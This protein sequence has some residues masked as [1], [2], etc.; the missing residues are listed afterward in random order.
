VPS[1][2]SSRIDVQ[3]AYA[4]VVEHLRRAIHLGEYGPGDKFPP[5][6][7]HAGELGVSRVTLRGAIRVLEGEGL[8]ETRRGSA[9]GVTVRAPA[10]TREQIIRRLRE[11]MDELIAIQQFRLVNERLAAER[12]ATRVSEQDIAALELSTEQLA[13]ATGIGPFRQADSSFHLRIAAAADSPLVQDAVARARAEM[14][15]PL[16]ALDYE[17]MLSDTLKDHRRILDALRARDAKKAGT[18]MAGHLR[19]TR[20]ELAAILGDRSPSAL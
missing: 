17:L 3:P 7:R 20:R 10:E 14:F 2:A 12:A 4:V 15:L 18:A 19:R 1:S 6:R 13:A 16:D 5:E 9:G 11:R 8:V